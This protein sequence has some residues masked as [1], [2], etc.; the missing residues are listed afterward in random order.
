MKIIFLISKINI[1]KLKVF[2]NHVYE[3]II[4]YNNTINQ[5]IDTILKIINKRIFKGNYF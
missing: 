1:N 4:I 3:L 2:N 5:K